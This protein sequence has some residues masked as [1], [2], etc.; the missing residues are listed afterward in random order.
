MYNACNLFIADSDN[1]K[2]PKPDIPRYGTLRP[3]SGS[4]PENA[5]VELVCG[6]NR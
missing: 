6:D 2:C 3:D 1:K 4:Y 5:R